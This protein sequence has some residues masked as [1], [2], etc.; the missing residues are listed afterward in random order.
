[1][2]VARAVVGLSAA[3]NTL[4]RAYVS[5]VTTPAERMAAMANVHI[6]QVT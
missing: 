4:S 2:I 1:M 6:A 5:G 3:V